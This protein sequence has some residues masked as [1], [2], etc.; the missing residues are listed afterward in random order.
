MDLEQQLRE[1]YAER[2][3]DL[4]LPAGNVAAARRT[5][6]RMRVRRRLGVSAAAV[7]V[8]AVALGGTLVGTGRVAVGPSHGT[9]HW[10]E[11]P[12]PPLSPRA[13]A[14]VVWTGREVVVL[15]GETQPCPPN[16]DCVSVSPLLRDGAAYDPSTDSWHPIAKS[17]VPVGSGSRLVA[18]DWHVVLRST[19]ESEWFVYDPDADS[20]SRIADVPRNAGDVPSALGSD[21]YV[22]AGRRVAVYGVG[23]DQWSMLPADP[24]QPRLGQRRVTATTSG[25]V[26]TGVDAT[27]P[28]DGSTPSLLLADVWDGT[29]W[30]RLPP[31]EQLGTGNSWTWT[32]T[33]MVDPDPFAMDGGEVDNW[34]RSYPQGGTLDPATGT[35]GS[36]PDALVD[37]ALGDHQGWDV[38]A[39]GGSWFAVVGQVYD[40][41]TGR[42][43]R[44]DAPDGAPT[45]GTGAAWADGRLLAFGG[46]TFGTERTHLTDRAWLWTP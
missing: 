36:L 40:D 30:H 18:A 35:W 32:G 38:S 31:S 6:A 41:A 10:R 26:V 37:P 11:L 46:A 33:R 3:G 9:G 39:T 45:S 21:V 19:V 15:G 13:N 12:V 7:A 1:S 5:G 23:E 25:V 17:P 34:G 43:Y 42:V 20:W 44:L 24:I 16:A 2:L 22:L 29:S 28:N 27:Q 8:L 4:D 14:Q